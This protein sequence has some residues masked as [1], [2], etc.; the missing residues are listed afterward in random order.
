MY[1]NKG[2]TGFSDKP[3]GILSKYE[4]VTS[5]YKNGTKKLITLTPYEPYTN[6]FGSDE[7]VFKLPRQGSG[8]LTNAY[9][10]SGSAMSQIVNTKT[11]DGLGFNLFRNTIFETESRTTK[12]QEYSN[13]NLALW[14]NELPIEPQ[15]YYISVASQTYSPTGITPIQ[16]RMVTPLGYLNIFQPDVAPLDL[17]Y[18]EQLQFRLQTNSINEMETQTTYVDDTDPENPV[19][20]SNRSSLTSL[21]TK[22]TIE[23][24][25]PED[26]GEVIG[27]RS[28]LLYD[29]YNERNVL[30]PD[31]APSVSTDLKC[32]REITKINGFIQEIRTDGTV[33]SLYSISNLS[34]KLGNLVLFDENYQSFNIFNQHFK[35]D[36]ANF[37]Y[38]TGYL[39]DK[40]TDSGKLKIAE[41]IPNL[42]IQA[43]VGADSNLKILLEY[44]YVLH[45]D[46]DGKVSREF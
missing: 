30:Y 14:I 17:R 18:V 39:K 2:S 28:Y 8:I 3:K 16:G 19:T 13:D 22:I 27:H 43:N 15:N 36:S 29:N 32:R 31:G 45:I 21:E 4:H 12:I 35:D 38:Y 7:M 34:F 26:T 23:V 9:I 5:I 40:G 11:F 37:R 25:I 42:T 24:W 10:H 1:Y 44:P 33:R 6:N 41:S 46:K 20:L